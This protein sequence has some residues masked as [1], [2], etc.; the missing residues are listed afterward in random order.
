[1]LFQKTGEK[2]QSPNSLCKT[3]YY[4]D[5]KTRL[6]CRIYQ[7]TGKYMSTRDSGK[8]LSLK[9]HCWLKEFEDPKPEPPRQ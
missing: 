8:T 2:G 1:M 9:Q 4:S 6:Y 5:N 3:W 7:A